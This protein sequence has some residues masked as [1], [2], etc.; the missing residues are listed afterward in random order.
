[1]MKEHKRLTAGFFRSVNAPELFKQFFDKFGAW[2]QLGLKEK[3]K[4][5]DIYDAWQ[6]F[7][8]AKRE[9]IDDALCCMNDISCEDG[10]TYLYAAAQEAGISDYK[11]LNLHKLALLLWLNHPTRFA[12]IYDCFIVEKNDNL[13]VLIGR[14]NTPCSP[15]SADFEKFKTSLREILRR[16]G[17]GPR[18]KIESLPETQDKWVLV[19]PH[20]HFMKPEHEFKTET[21]IGTRDRRPVHELVLIYYPEKGLLKLKVG[22]KGMRKAEAIASLFATNILHQRGDHFKAEEI[23]CFNPL[24]RPGFN[25]PVRPTDEFE[26]AKVVGM[27]Y[28]HAGDKNFRHQITCKDTIGGTQDVIGKLQTGG[29]RLQD[30][31]IKSLAIQFQFKGGGR[32]KRKTVMLT[33]PHYYTLDETPRDRHI[34]E[35]L[36]RWGFINVNANRTVAVA[37]A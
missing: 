29:V 35:V 31:D 34:E 24:L 11:D 37:T 18:L 17:E 13:K 20:E 7:V 16:G 26:W 8:H 15:S 6:L 32:K 12:S 2:Q 10:R 9:S 1:M 21:T 23:V 14:P 28:T 33:R 22:G 5:D 19:V 27:N 3:P 25:F 36:M 4:N 30:A